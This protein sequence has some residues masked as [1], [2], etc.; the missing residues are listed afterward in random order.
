MGVRCPDWLLGWDAQRGPFLEMNEAQTHTQRDRENQL[1]EAVL[2]GTEIR[3][4]A[5]YQEV[6]EFI[7]RASD[8]YYLTG[9]VLCDD[10]TYDALVRMVEAAEEANP[11]WA[12]DGVRVSEAVAAGAGVGGEYTHA[13]PMLSLDNVFADEDLVGF[14]E[15]VAVKLGSGKLGSGMAEGG[16]ELYVTVEP[17]LDGLAISAQYEDGRLTRLVTRGDGVTGEVVTHLVGRDQVD[18]LPATIAGPLGEG[19]IEVRGEMIMTEAQFEEA[20]RRRV[21]AGKSA[22]ANPRNAVAGSVR[23]QDRSYGIPLTFVSYDLVGAEGRGYASHAEAM[24]GLGDA[25]FISSAVLTLPD[26]AAALMRV[27]RDE[28]HKSVERIGVLRAEMGFLVDGAVVKADSYA[29]RATLGLGSRAPRWAVAYKYPAEMVLTRLL[30][31][32]MSVGRTGRVTPVAVLEPVEVG[33]VV[34]TSATL[35]NHQDLARKDVRIG[36]WV[37]VR[38]AGEVIPEVVGPELSKREDGVAAFEPAKTCPRCGGELETSEMVWRC[39]NRSCGR[40][41]ALRYFASR[42]V[43]DIDGLGEGAV[44]ALLDAGLVSDPADLYALEVSE[45]AR[46]DRFGV[47]SA[48]NLVAAIEGSKSAGL[49]RVLASLGIRHLGRRLSLRVARHYGSMTALLEAVDAHGAAAL[50]EIE[51]FGGVKAAEAVAGLAENRDL[52]AKLAAAGVEMTLAAGPSA[53]SESETGG[54]TAALAGKKVLVTGTVPGY[55]RD[56][57]AER[58]AEAGGDVA[59]SVS[60]KLDAVLV[61]ANPGGSKITKAESLGLRIIDVSAEGELDR[62]CR[63]GL[64]E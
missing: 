35:N 16:D 14:W 21:A 30:G 61:G 52:I 46:L 7:R 29:D 27:K 32:E 33:G 18:G 26:G 36:D 47:K 1:V 12:V 38:R 40:A 24:A 60:G 2:G 9:E 11:E 8:A 44:G 20:N 6:V 28:M 48:E 13:E 49:P 45:V 59:S 57:A 41:E 50:A 25:G 4:L 10:P 39:P 56:G 55:T 51:G 62:V 15:K 43:M 22:F 31:I 34:V 17:K 3:D 5:T 58:V 63:E 53:E 19:S 54:E 42:T 23:A 37:W 64:G